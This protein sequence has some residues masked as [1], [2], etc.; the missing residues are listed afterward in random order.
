MELSNITDQP[1]ILV[2]D[3]QI[4]ELAD[5]HSELCHG[6]YASFNGGADFEELECLLLKMIDQASEI[7]FLINLKSY[8]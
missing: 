4:Q 2:T 3:S 5:K 7:S 8:I 1:K 6:V